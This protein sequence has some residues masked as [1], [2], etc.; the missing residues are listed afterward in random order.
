MTGIAAA[1][2]IAETPNFEV[3][4]RAVGALIYLPTAFNRTWAVFQ[5][6]GDVPYTK[7]KG[8]NY[9]IVRKLNRLSM[10]YVLFIYTQL[11]SKIYGAFPGPINS[12]VDIIVFFVIAVFM[13][14]SRLAVHK[15]FAWK[16]DHEKSLYL[17]TMTQKFGGTALEVWGYVAV[18]VILLLVAHLAPLLRIAQA[19]MN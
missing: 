8:F 11:I 3:I 15:E 4:S 10:F 12:Y 5:K 19:F 18:T 7:S 13:T 16:D 14:R 6:V 9:D 1:I 2:A 17:K